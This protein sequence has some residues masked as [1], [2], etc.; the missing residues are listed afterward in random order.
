MTQSA[1]YL[2]GALGPMLIGWLSDA[3]HRF[4]SAVLGLVVVTLMLIAVQLLVVPHP[5]KSTLNLSIRR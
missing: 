2:I 1:G 5:A 4:S 3:T